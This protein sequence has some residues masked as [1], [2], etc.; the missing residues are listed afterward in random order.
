MATMKDVAKKANVSVST[1]SRAFRNDGYIHARTLAAIKSAAAELDYIIDMNA[2]RLRNKKNNLVGLIVS[3]MHNYFYNLVLEEVG[4]IAKQRGSML[5]ISNSHENVEEERESFNTFLSA[6]VSTIIFTPISIDNRYLV[7][8]ALKSNIRVIQ[9]FRKVYDDI[10]SIIVDDEYGAYL[11]TKYLLDCGC[12]N[13]LLIE[14]DLRNQLGEKA[15]NVRSKGYLKAMEEYGNKN[16]HILKHQ[17][18]SN[19]EQELCETIEIKK[20]DGIICAT[21]NFALELLKVVRENN[22]P[23]MK[24]VTFDDLE[25]VEHLGLTAIRQPIDKI[26]SI[27]ASRIGLD[28]SE[29]VIDKKIKPELIVR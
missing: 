24:I 7:E 11:V 9:L 1:V 5:L 20:P 12:R 10:D 29:R 22:L 13:P 19:M 8:L 26:S 23:S 3:D 21:N 16:I 28:T 18:N 27:I 6:K 2:S 17:I 4:T 15:E 25:W 14:V